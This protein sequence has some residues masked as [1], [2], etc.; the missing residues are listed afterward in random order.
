MNCVRYNPH[1][2]RVLA[3]VQPMRQATQAQKRSVIPSI[4][5]ELTIAV[6]LYSSVLDWQQPLH[7]LSSL[8]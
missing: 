5:W 8:E 2:Y 7:N 1:L 3:I 4:L 6:G